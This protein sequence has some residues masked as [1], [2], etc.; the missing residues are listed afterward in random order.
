MT[1][2]AASPTVLEREDVTRAIPVRG[3]AAAPLAQL[4]TAAAPAR[5]ADAAGGWV[6]PISIG[7]GR[8]PWA[9]D[10]ER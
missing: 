10:K 9:P 1:A 5:A 2:M 8:R 7:A 3:P 4:D 6:L